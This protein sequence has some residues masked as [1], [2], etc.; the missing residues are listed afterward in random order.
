MPGPLSHVR[1][2]ELSRVLA[3]PWAAQTLADLGADVI[4]VERPGAGDDTRAWGPPWAG[5]ESAYFLS[6]NRG[7]RSITID[8]ERPEGQEL[9]RKLAAQAD[10]VIE[11]FKVGGLVKYGLDYDSL[12]AVNP[13]LVYCSITGF[14]QDGPYAKRAGYDFMIQGMGGLMSITGQPDAEAGG[15]PVKVGVAVTDVF[16]GLYATIGVL[17]ALAHRDR[18]GEGQWVNLALLDVQVAVLANQAMNYLVGGKA[19]QRLG[20]AHPNIVPYQAF[21][22]L[23]GHIILSVGNDGQ[24][25]KFCQV[26]GRP[27]LA[28]DPRYA[29]NPAR[30]ANRKEL[31]PILELLLEQRTSRDWLSAL[32]AVGVPCGPIN[33]V[34][35][36]FAD[37][38]V[39]AR[40]IH[41]DLPH[42]TAGTV[43]TVASPIR[44]SATPI[45]HT[46]APPTLGQHTDAVLEQALGLCAADIAALREKGVV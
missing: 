42:P 28:Q 32:E 31:V 43:P 25:A 26:A 10:V 7:K 16:T 34:S 44:Y 5:E 29:T 41:Q 21:A 8:F 15:G 1:V 40:H 9:V 4:K 45:E 14:G 37:P 13:G 22:T 38:H 2:L 27:E 30:V 17:G 6:T 35:Q 46:V 39:Q 33:D 12:K 19:P 23:D 3:G 11:N 20:N 36:V 24:F 18:T